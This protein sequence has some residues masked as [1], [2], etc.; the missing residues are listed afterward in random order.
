[1]DRKQ[2]KQLLA[3][4]LGIIEEL[5]I[6][7]D[8]RPTALQL[9]WADLSP[10]RAAVPSTSPA[11]AAL[12]STSPEEA[13]SSDALK[14]LGTRLGISD[15]G[16]LADLYATTED[17]M[18][19]VSV[20]TTKLPAEKAASTTQLALL[21]CAGRQAAGESVTLSATLRAVCEQYGKLNPPNFA[22]T[23]KDA[24]QLWIIGGPRLQKTYK[25]R[26]PGWEE[27]KK[28]VKQ[29]ADIS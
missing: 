8:L 10:A 25:L 23:L 28:L 16:R 19:E 7:E 12:P 3:E 9:L 26:N 15:L 20:P 14:A 29:L 13:A 4:V 11:P 18:L 27:A 5:D 22:R 1:M 24:D 21:T 17:G 6:P 2:A